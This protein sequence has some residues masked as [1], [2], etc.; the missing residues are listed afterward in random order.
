MRRCYCLFLGI[1]MLCMAACG[2]PNDKHEHTPAITGVLPV[3]V[4]MAETTSSPT[5]PVS[6]EPRFLPID[7]PEDFLV[8]YWANEAQDKTF[9]YDYI[10]ES[11]AFPSSFHLSPYEGDVRYAFYPDMQFLRA[12]PQGAL[13]YPVYEHGTWQLSENFDLLQLNISQRHV[14][15]KDATYVAEDI[16]FQESIAISI[17]DEYLYCEEKV[18]RGIQRDTITIDDWEF[19]RSNIE[20][21]FLNDFSYATTGEMHNGNSWDSDAD[22]TYYDGKNGLPKIYFEG[23]IIPG[24]EEKKTWAGSEISFYSYHIQVSQGTY[25]LLTLGNNYATAASMEAFTISFLCDEQILNYEARCI[26]FTGV[27]YFH[28]G[29][30]FSIT[31]FDV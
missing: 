25:E 8:G 4:E 24:S 31:D 20:W 22:M 10:E 2:A 3:T 6:A 23:T 15:N 27:A 13:G 21:D 16:D 19:L 28:D 11:D 29:F 12:I 17:G 18:F 5:P 9:E 30:H 14:P 26:R 1:L 7:N